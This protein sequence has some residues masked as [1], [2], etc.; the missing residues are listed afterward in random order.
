MQE[1]CPFQNAIFTLLQGEFFSCH[2]QLSFFFFLF[3]QGPFQMSGPIKH[4][5]TG[6]LVEKRNTA[7]RAEKK[8]RLIMHIHVA[9]RFNDCCL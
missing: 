5:K 7:Q 8:N 3:I 4:N 9:G 1:L 2:K 6:L